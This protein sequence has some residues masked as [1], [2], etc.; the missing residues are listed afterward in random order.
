RPISQPISFQLALS[1]ATPSVAGYTTP[2]VLERRRRSDPSPEPTASAL[3]ECRAR[4]R[5]RTRYPALPRSPRS[6]RSPPIPARAD[7]LRPTARGT[8]RPT[9]PPRTPPASPAPAVR[10]ASA[11][12]SPVGARVPPVDARSLPD[13]AED[14]SHR[15]EARPPSQ[16]SPA[17]RPP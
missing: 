11:R 6:P 12:S 2:S 17:P 10:P 7:T 8:Q 16:W 9:Q 13:A 15:S 14:D 4:L 5:P 3:H 1:A